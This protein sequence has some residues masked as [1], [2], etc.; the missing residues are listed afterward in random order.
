MLKTY[1]IFFEPSPIPMWVF[2]GVALLYRIS[3]FPSFGAAKIV[4]NRSKKI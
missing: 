3:L 1:Y 4:E 2:I